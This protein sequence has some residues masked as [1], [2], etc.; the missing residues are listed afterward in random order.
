M[1]ATRTRRL[2]R[3][4]GIFALLPLGVVVLS[5]AA[6]QGRMIYPGQHYAQEMWDRVPADVEPLRYRTDQGDQVSFYQKPR[7]GGEP[8][9]L[10]LVCNGNGGYALQWPDLLP[11]ARDADA[12]FLLLDYPGYG[13][14]E[15]SCTPGRIL[16][17][18]EGAVEALRERLQ[19][20]PGAFDARLGVFGHSLGAAAALQY[21]AR[22]SVR[23]I[24]LAAPFTS[25]VAMGNHL[26]FWPCGQLIWHRFDN[27]DRLAEIARQQPRPPVLIL[28]GGD[29]AMIP[30]AMSAEL[31]APYA[32]WVERIVVPGVDHDEVALDAVK[33]LHEP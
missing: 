11:A 30:P 24:V 31:A 27:V 12:G 10:W 5:M 29:D 15:G 26:L 9:R 7:S 13:F 14:S 16:A 8:K 21:A 6:C 1:T 32:G 3:A 33:A 25:M 23:R 19:L 20:P 17:A 4:L 2:A 28:H 22:H 18:S